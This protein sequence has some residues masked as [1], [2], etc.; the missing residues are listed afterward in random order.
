M[1]TPLDRATTRA[2]EEDFAEATEA[3]ERYVEEMTGLVSTAGP[4]LAIVTDRAEWVK[5][6]IGSFRRL[7]RP[8]AE[9]LANGTE[10][11][12]GAISPLNRAAAGAEVGLLLTWISSRV[13]GQYDLLPGE[14]T[15]A[16]DAVYYVG[17]NIVA[18]ERRNAFPPKE[19]RL[20][21]AVHE[22][23]HRV[24]FTGVPW[25]RD[26]F[27]DLVE[28]GTNLSPPDTHAV[29]DSLRRA[30][31]ELRAGRNPL[32]EGG[33]VGLIANSEQLEMLREAQALMSLLEGHGDVIMSRVGLERIPG[34]PR[35]ARVLAERR[36]STRGAA[37]LIQ[38][39]LGIEAKL[40]QYAEGERFVETVLDEGGDELFA[41]VWSSASMLPTMEEIKDPSR[42]IARAGGVASSVG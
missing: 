39:A 18:I 37:K 8:V 20:W 32:A 25:L 19:F 33:V 11:Q 16:K 36:S 7:L 6:N 9:R 35:F 21:I 3:A 10:R 17:P 42:W 1:T 28:R 41:R 5:A 4:A 15:S 29:L 14:E 24:Q 12:K 26:Y 27:L 31:G 30:V 34:A 2:L 40:R 22:V 13:L 38:Q 23:T